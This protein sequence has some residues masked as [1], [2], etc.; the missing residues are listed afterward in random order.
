VSAVWPQGPRKKATATLA[1][2]WTTTPPDGS[3][4]EMGVVLLNIFFGRLVLHAA[5]LFGV[6]LFWLGVNTVKVLCAFDVFF[7]ETGSWHH[8]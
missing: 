1:R 8:I 7:T 3:K 5:L 6:M 4:R 2:L